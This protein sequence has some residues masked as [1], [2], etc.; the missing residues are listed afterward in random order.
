MVLVTLQDETS[1]IDADVRGT[2]WLPIDDN[3]MEKGHLA[4]GYEKERARTCRKQND[5]AVQFVVGTHS[6][7]EKQSL[8][9]VSMFQTY[10]KVLNIMRRVHVTKLFTT[11]C[12]RCW[13]G[14]VSATNCTLRL[15]ECCALSPFV[16]TARA[17]IAVLVLRW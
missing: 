2:T 7:Y 4:D 10:A 6:K 1:H 5:T 12:A 9:M 8:P 3:V 15:I 11:S 16:C 17:V 13:L 14:Q